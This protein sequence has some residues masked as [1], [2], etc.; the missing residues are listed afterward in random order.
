M[1]NLMSISHNAQAKPFY[2]D[3]RVLRTLCVS[4]DSLAI[5]WRSVYDGGDRAAALRS[6]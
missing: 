3:D 5:M 4:S 2:V 6:N 1:G